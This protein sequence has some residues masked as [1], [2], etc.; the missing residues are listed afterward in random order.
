MFNV[1]RTIASQV[2]VSAVNQLNVVANKLEQ[3]VV[4]GPKTQ[5]ADMLDR[6]ATGQTTEGED[7]FVIQ[8]MAKTYDMQL[9]K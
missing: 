6:F 3:S 7:V 5:A 2:L 4:Y 9:S 1:I 8:S